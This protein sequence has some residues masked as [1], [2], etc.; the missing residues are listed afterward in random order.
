M[1]AYTNMP[2]QH[3]PSHTHPFTHTLTYP[4]THSLTHPFHPPPL[5]HLYQVGSPALRLELSQAPHT[6]GLYLPALTSVR[7]A[8]GHYTNSLISSHLISHPQYTPSIH[9][10]ITPPNTQSHLT[11]LTHVFSHPQHILSHNLSSPSYPLH[12]PIL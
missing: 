9:A 12:T 5:I 1:F 2:S 3:T 4:N 6:A 7:R 10:F 11:P 8:A